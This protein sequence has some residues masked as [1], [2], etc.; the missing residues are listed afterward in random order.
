MTIWVIIA[1]HF[2]ADFTLQPTWLAKAKKE[3]MSCLLI[4]IAIY[5]VLIG[6]ITF[7]LVERVN[8]VE[9]LLLISGTH[10]VVDGMKI[11][12]EKQ[13]LCKRWS[14]WMFVID[15][16]IHLIVLMF[17]RKWYVC[18]DYYTPL[19]ESVL[20]W[21]KSSVAV[22]YIVTF[23]ILWDPASVFINKLF[24]CFFG[25]DREGNLDVGPLD[26]GSVVGKLE[27]LIIAM[28]VFANQWGAI[29]F[30]LTAKSIARYKQI[31]ENNNAFAEKYLI[32]TLASAAISIAVPFLLMQFM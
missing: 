3:R 22:L 27:R 9:V 29:G 11:A 24:V 6:S 12:I 21:E 2:V 19:W 8:V 5:T 32:G 10:F 30:V 13:N 14:L 16:M 18:E 7:N 25:D 26:I 31:G 1:A 17:L 23:V 15:Q 4:H 20:A 28:L